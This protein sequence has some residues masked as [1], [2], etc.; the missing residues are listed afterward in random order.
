MEGHFG[1]VTC[2]AISPNGLFAISGSEDNTARVWGLT[3]GFVVSIFKVLKNPI[4]DNFFGA[5]ISTEKGVLNRLVLA[6]Y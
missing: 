1:T 2:V 5:N 6:A 4:V 3:L